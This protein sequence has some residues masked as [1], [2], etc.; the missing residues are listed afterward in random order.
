[1]EKF[2]FF[3]VEERMGRHNDLASILP[4]GFS[5]GRMRFTI[6]QN[7]HTTT[8]INHPIDIFYQSQVLLR[9]IDAF[10]YVRFGKTD[11]MPQHA[12]DVNKWRRWGNPLAQTVPLTE[13]VDPT[14]ILLS[15]TDIQ[16]RIREYGAWIVTSSWMTFTGITDDQTQMA[17]ILLDNM[18]LTMD[19]LTRDVASGGASRTTASNGSG[20]STFINKVDLDI[21][22]TNLLVQ[23]TRMME[24]QIA[25]STL[26][27]TS[28]ISSSFIGIC[29][30]GQRTKLSQVSGFKR[31]SSYAQDKQMKD[32][33][34]ATDDIRWILST[35][36]T[37]ATTT[38]GYQNL[39][40][41]Q[42]FY[43]TVKIK[44]N[45]AS[46]PLIFHGKDRVNS[47][48]E[49]FTTLGWLQ[50]FAAQILNDNFGHVLLTTV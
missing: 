15:K 14:P 43:G 36:A 12:G 10:V 38:T 5:A 46:A 29:H 34:G 3:S 6:N 49:R 41:G 30:V 37:R 9:V 1:M 17:D 18:R 22:V 42:E 45:S 8:R 16:V 4:L 40:F 26:V 31:V 35:N 32:E 7:M 24:D 25:A 13:G 39:I 27:A 2:K 11:S 44:G 21:I 48:L 28:P 47:P 50:N 19:T 23:N 20:T 33:F